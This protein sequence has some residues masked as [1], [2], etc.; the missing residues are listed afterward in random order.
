M[1]SAQESI[2]CEFAT[3]KHELQ[4]YGEQPYTVHL[5]AVRNILQW[6]GV[7]NDHPLAIAAWLHDTLEDT[8]TTHD[9]ITARFGEEVTALVWAVTG[10]G[11]NRK[12]RN[13]HAYAKMRAHPSAITLK[14]ADRIA[15]VEASAT[16][17]DKLAMYQK[18]WPSFRDALAGHGP[19]A[20]WQRLRE[21]LGLEH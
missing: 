3:K 4:R 11:A 1:L 9:E 15:N 20:L 13:A 10:V 21:A 17:P 8:N 16:V 19:P 6:A 7:E 5:Q 18:E 2:A 12:E 14:L